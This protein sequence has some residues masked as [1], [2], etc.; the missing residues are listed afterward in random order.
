MAQYLSQG[1]IRMFGIRINRGYLFCDPFDISR[2]KTNKMLKF[3]LHEKL[4][5]QWHVQQAINMP[6]RYHF[7]YLIVLF[8][9]H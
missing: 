6:P 2:S 5:R 9:H 1:R 3:T 7:W 4:K 8:A